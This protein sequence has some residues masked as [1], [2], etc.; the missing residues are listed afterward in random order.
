MWWTFLSAAP[1]MMNSMLKM[2]AL[3]CA[4]SEEHKQLSSND[5]VLVL[6]GET[7]LI[8]GMAWVAVAKHRQRVREPPDA[9]A[10]G[11]IRGGFWTLF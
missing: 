1:T 7:I 2:M 6:V 11:A 8:V 4:C 10:I 3:G 5:W 9:G